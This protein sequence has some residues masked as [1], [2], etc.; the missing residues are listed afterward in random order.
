MDLDTPSMPEAPGLPSPSQIVAS[1]SKVSLGS[2]VTLLMLAVLNKILSVVGGPPVVGLFSLLRQTENTGIAVAS[3]DGDRALVQGISSRAGREQVASFTWSIGLFMAAVTLAEVAVL[4]I[5]A[6][7][8]AGW[9]FGQSITAADPTASADKIA[10]VR[11]IGVPILLAVGSTWLVAILKGR[12]AV[13]KAVLVRTLGAVAGVA[14]ALAAARSGTA[15]AIVVLLIIM[16]A[17][18]LLTGL[19]MVVSEHALPASPA[20]AWPQHRDNVSSYLSVAGYL[21]VGGILRNL[22][23]LPIRVLFAREGGLT[24][25]GYFDTAWTLTAKYLFFLLDAISTYYLPLLSAARAADHRGK[26]LKRLVRLAWAVSMPA[27]IGLIVL[28]PLVVQILYAADFLPSL[29]LLR[30]MLI[31]NYFQASAWLFSTAMLAFGDVRSAFRVDVAWFALFLA[32]SVVSLG[33]YHQVQG[34]GITFLVAYV[35]A[36]LVTGWYAVRRYGMP[37]GRR[38]SIAWGLGLLLVL[39]A[40]VATWNDAGVAWMQVLLWVSLSGLV[41][42]ISFDPGELRSFLKDVGLR[43]RI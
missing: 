16:E 1:F 36:F 22:V 24:F 11:W 18:T 21:L 30:W 33:G 38:M 40:S 27:V 35:G 3:S 32:G 39:A 6:A 43:R 41:V 13:G 9:M 31:G 28:K 20:P 8:I 14:G 7:P 4:W 12:L 19:A 23:V 29:D 26:L 5:A 25:A 15:V 10:A 34:V 17:V 37:V 2:A 42:L